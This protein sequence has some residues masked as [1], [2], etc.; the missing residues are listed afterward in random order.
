MENNG[1]EFTLNT[2]PVKNNKIT[3]DLGFNVTYN[4][5]K[6]TNLLKQSDA[7]FTGINVSGISG[8]T[9]NN[10]GKFAVGKAP[11]F[12]NVS[13]KCMIKQVV[14]QLKVYMKI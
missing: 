6:I 5:T 1:V 9:G 13:N 2:T 4:N 8:G 11:F 14:A 12:F 3:W 10:I 7:N